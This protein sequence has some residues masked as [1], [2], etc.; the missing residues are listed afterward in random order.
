MLSAKDTIS[1]LGGIARGTTLQ[2]LG[3]TRQSLA[4]D[5]K[6]GTIDRVRDGVFAVGLSGERRTAVEHG[7]ALTCV[8]ALREAGIWVL[9]ADDRPHVW[10]GAHRHPLR[11]PGCRCVSH[12]YRGRPPLGA[13]SIEAA[14]LHLY[15]CAGDE[16]FFA[17][18]E[19]AWR[20]S[21]LSRDARAR[22][23]NALPRTA[24]WLI[25]LA[26]PDADSGLESLLRLRLHLL[27]IRLDCQVMIE[28]VGRV[29]FVIA[30]RLILEADGEEN[31]GS[32]AHRHRDRIRDAAAS[33]LGYETLRFDY[34]QIVHGWPAVQEAII[35]ALRRNR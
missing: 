17:A 9:S 6:R 10:M 1:R 25:D 15:R 18:Y 27:G 32:P 3:F 4:A 19:S 16:A 14:L 24:R 29:D 20:R 35:A 12:H 33:R 23:R 22:I 30:K 8:S 21:R 7:G 28:G 13:A 11:H 2:G 26:R 34:A 31:H 5:V